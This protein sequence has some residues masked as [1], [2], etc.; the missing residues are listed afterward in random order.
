VLAHP[1]RGEVHHWPHGHQT[2]LCIT[3]VTAVHVYVLIDYFADHFEI[4]VVQDDVAVGPPLP[5]TAV[6]DDTA[7]RAPW[8]R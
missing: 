5:G 7:V 3:D 8:R 4:T 1:I 6:L 2:A